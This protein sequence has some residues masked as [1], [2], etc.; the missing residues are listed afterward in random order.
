MDTIAVIIMIVLFFLLLAFVFSTA[1]LTPLIGKKNLLSVILLGFVVGLI[2]GAFFIAPIFDDIPDMA[3]AV[4][5]STSNEPEIIGVNISTDS[6]VNQAMDNIKNIEGVKSVESGVITLKTTTISDDWKRILEARMTTT[7]PNVTSVKVISSD[8]IVVQTKGGIN[9]TD[10]IKKLKDWINLVSGITV[11][12]SIVEVS[13]KV[14]ASK[15]DEVLRKMPQGDVVVTSV[16]GPVENEIQSLKNLLPQK[17]DVILFCG[18][19]GVITGLFG[20]FIDTII[21]GLKGFKGRRKKNNK[22][23]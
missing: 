10:V 15:A 16:N 14:D 18:F 11:K 22:K 12:Y 3:R 9:P 13:V 2:G 6:N 23:K 5:M 4:Y 8:T 1:L 21:G 19:L 20:M 17:S 7:N